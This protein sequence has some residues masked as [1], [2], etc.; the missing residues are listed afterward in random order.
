M[1]NPMSHP[2]KILK[3]VTDTR[4]T[5]RLWRGLWP[6]LWAHLSTPLWKRDSHSSSRLRHSFDARESRLRDAKNRGTSP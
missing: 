2:E 4:G 6:D 5:Q 1:S 3:P